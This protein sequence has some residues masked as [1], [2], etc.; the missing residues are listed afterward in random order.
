MAGAFGQKI[1]ARK[2]VLNHFSPRYPGND[3]V[4]EDAKRIMSA[5]KS[6][7]ESTYGG[8]VICA[9]DLMSFEVE[10]RK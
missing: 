8:E 6:L 10:I 9:R 7:A 3:D 4:D 1:E 5:I 2:L